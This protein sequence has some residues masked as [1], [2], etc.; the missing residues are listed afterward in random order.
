MNKKNIIILTSISAVLILSIFVFLYK[1]DTGNNQN[2]TQDFKNITYYLDNNPI[3]LS[4]ADIKYFGNELKKD[5]NNDRL[6]DITF[7]YTKNSQGSG[8]FYYVTS[9]INSN[10]GFIGTN[11]IFLGDRIAP[12]NI[13]FNN[14]DIVVNFAD[15]KLEEPMTTQPSVGVSKY[16]KFSNN[17]LIETKKDN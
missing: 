15:R 8:V 2:K 9:A 17:S 6:E 13:E 1:K 16:I 11:S 14:G 7:L 10:K 3:K 12:Q 5:I 4:D